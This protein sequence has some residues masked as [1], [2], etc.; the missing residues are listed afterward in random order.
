MRTKN[1]S[2]TLQATFDCVDIAEGDR[3]VHGDNDE[4]IILRG[5]QQIHLRWNSITH[6]ANWLIKNKEHLGDPGQT[7][8]LANKLLNSA[9]EIDQYCLPKD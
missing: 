2:T 7:E 9:N 3:L 8:F 4:L 6:Y 5:A 1:Q